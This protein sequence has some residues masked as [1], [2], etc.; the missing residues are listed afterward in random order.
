MQFLL[1]MNNAVNYKRS[2]KVITCDRYS[3][4]ASTQRRPNR[5][6]HYGTIQTWFS[7]IFWS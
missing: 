3:N 4:W 1:H 2:W 6:L 5:Y 7:V